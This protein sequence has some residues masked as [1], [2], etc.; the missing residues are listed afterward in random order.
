MFYKHFLPFC[1]LHFHCFESV[2]RCA[3]LLTLKKFIFS[4]L[5]LSYSWFCCVHFYNCF[6]GYRLSYWELLFK[7]PLQHHFIV[8]WPSYFLM[9]IFSLTITPLKVTFFRLFYLAVG[10]SFDLVIFVSVILGL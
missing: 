6:I 3:K 10:Y 1:G 7:V 8:F 2:L 4:M 9:K 5:L